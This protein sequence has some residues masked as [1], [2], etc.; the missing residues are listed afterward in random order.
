[1]ASYRVVIHKRLF[2]CLDLLTKLSMS[3]ARSN[4]GGALAA[5]NLDAKK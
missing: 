4:E 1:M 3:Y 2:W 5:R